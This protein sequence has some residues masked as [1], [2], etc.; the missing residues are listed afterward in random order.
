ALS[1]R[2]LCPELWRAP[3]WTEGQTLL[4]HRIGGD[5]HGHPDYSVAPCGT[6]DTNAY[7][8]PTGFSEPPPEPAGSRTALPAVGGWVPDRRCRRAL[9]YQESAGRD[10]DLPV[11]SNPNNLDPATRREAK[12]GAPSTHSASRNPRCPTAHSSSGH[13]YASGSFR[14]RRCS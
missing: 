5:R 7:A 8:Q 6:G 14:R 3:G 12:N 13:A 1:D 9:H 2:D 4:S 11:A 10:C